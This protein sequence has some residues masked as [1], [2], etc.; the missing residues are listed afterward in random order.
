MSVRQGTNTIAGS[1]YTKSEVDTL[2][3]GKADTALSNLTSTGKEKASTLSMPSS[4]INTLTLGVSGA[5]YTA[6]SDG[7]VFVNF[8]AQANASAYIQTSTLRT[9][10]YNINFPSFFLPV[11]KGTIFT[12]DYSGG[13]PVL[14][15]V[16][17]NGA[18]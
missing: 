7:Y 10:A 1:G 15:F 6:P 12:V 5:S 13:T 17:S 2:L 3:T 9:G 4:S 14:Y 8:G 16:Y 11:S 18:I